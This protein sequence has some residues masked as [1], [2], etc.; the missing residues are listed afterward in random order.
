MTFLGSASILDNYVFR[1]FNS[2][3]KNAG[4]EVEEQNKFCTELL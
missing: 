1:C 4:R 2:K 3:T